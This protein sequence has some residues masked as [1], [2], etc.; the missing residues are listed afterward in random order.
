MSHRNYYVVLGI[1][2]DESPR[3]IRAAYLDLAR[4]H[5]PDR[6][7]QGATKTLQEINEAYE[8]L[9]DPHRRREYNHQLDLQADRARRAEDVVAPRATSA[10]PLVPDPTAFGPADPF[11]IFGDP[12]AV[13]PS[14]QELRD[15]IVRNF[16]GRHVPKSEH[17]T[18]LHLEVILTSH[19]A[20]HGVVLPIQ[21]PVFVSC[22]RCAGTG[23]VWA[24]PCVDCECQGIV[25]RDRTVHLRIPAGV[26]RG[27]VYEI[28]L[29]SLGIHNVYLRID[30]DIEDV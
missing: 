3:G 30:V 12:D 17:L 15:R 7:G 1:P 29:G 22:A 6:A 20:L 21:L 18:P 23:R 11:S 24:F 2:R 28:G 8:T 9:S 16:T 13:L 26:R 10:E 25:E 19:E 4:Q 5:H 14:F 27:T